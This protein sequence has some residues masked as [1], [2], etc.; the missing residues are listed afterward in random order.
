M[1]AIISEGAVDGDVE[2]EQNGGTT[3]LMMNTLELSYDVTT[4]LNT[5]SET[6]E[7]NVERP[8]APTAE[9]PLLSPVSEDVENVEER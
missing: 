4:T 7:I 2:L 3:R 1:Q 9:V 8:D 5:D 6:L